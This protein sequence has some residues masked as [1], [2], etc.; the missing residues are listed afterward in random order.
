MSLA[1]ESDVASGILCVD[2][3][4]NGREKNRDILFTNILN[5]VRV[6]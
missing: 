3:M 6:S 5:A 2:Y 1:T 4:I